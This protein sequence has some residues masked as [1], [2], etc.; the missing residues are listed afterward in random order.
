LKAHLNPFA[1]DRVQRRLPFDPELIGTTW[2]EIESQFQ[3]LNRRAVVW[4]HHGSGKSTFL[5]SFATRLE[6][7]RPVR[8]LFFQQGNSH[9]SSSQKAVLQNLN[10]V[11]L[12]VDGEGHLARRD[13]ALLRKASQQAAG[14]LAVRHH[15]ALL[16]T[17]LR[18]HSNAEVARELLT[19]IDATAAEAHQNELPTLLRKN[20]GN[21]RE[22]WLSLYDKYA[23]KK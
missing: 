15:P 9:L 2:E 23:F 3:K 1:P 14:Y 19:R 5:K 12:L 21:L 16:P 18:L 17:L 6:K 7:N 11:D 10:G 22:M 13:K 4:G 8:L 20:R